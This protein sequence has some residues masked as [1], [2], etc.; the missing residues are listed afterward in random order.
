M[1]NREARG[2]QAESP[3]VRGSGAPGLGRCPRRGVTAP[4]VGGAG[5]GGPRAPAQ[6]GEELELIL[7]LDARP[8]IGSGGGSLEERIRRA[9]ASRRPPPEGC[10][11]LAA[12]RPHDL[13]APPGSAMF[14]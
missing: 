1:G 7:N 3:Q 14:A 10:V 8:R 12:S 9:L 11:F 5:P 6:W 13:S 4:P 2:R